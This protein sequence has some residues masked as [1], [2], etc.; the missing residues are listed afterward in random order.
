MHISC[1]YYM[2]IYLA[3]L[4]IYLIFL[5]C[6][7]VCLPRL[8]LFQFYFHLLLLVFPFRLNLFYHQLLFHPFADYFFSLRLLLLFFFFLGFSDLSFF[9][10][11]GSVLLLLGNLFLGFS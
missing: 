7:G 2:L 5:F 11:L 4:T 1:I 3:Q 6:F 8:L 9:L 10:L